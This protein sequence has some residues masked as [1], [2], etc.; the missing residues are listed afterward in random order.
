MKINR[1]L[2]IVI[3]LLNRKTITAKELAEQFSVS[4]RT[5][6]RDIDVLSSAG[7]PVYTNK[8]NGGGISLL[9]DY[10]LNKT[11]L[12]EPEVQG[13]L[14]ALKAMGI[15]QYPQMNAV[16]DKLGGLFKNHRTSADWIDI[17]LMPWN[18]HP[19]EQNKFSLIRDA[20]LKSQTISFD[21][22]NVNAEKSFRF[23]EPE[24]LIFHMS[25]WYLEGFCLKR[26]THRTFRLSRIK[27]VLLTDQVFVQRPRTN[28]QTMITDL[29]PPNYIPLKLKFSEKALSRVYDTFDE[30]LITKNADGTFMVNVELPEDEWIYSYLL[31]F[32]SYAE[33][34]EPAHL[35]QNIKER[36]REALES[37]DT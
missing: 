19:N 7:V 22:V 15:T 6:Y 8:G 36:M 34:L 4:V 10:T 3:I 5:I 24:R 27:N 1:L 20:I 23:V 30:A 2:E 14:L 25:T 9:E 17:H 35:R 33:I 31:S 16:M 29:P 32:G 11:L 26:N 21:Y 12:T 28:P 18:S 13:L 37:Y